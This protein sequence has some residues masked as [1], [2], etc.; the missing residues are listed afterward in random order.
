MAADARVASAPPWSRRAR[1]APSRALAAAL[2]V[3]G[4]YR[5]AR[6][7][8]PAEAPTALATELVGIPPLTF[9][10]GDINGEP[11]EYPERQITVKGFSLERTEV[12]NV[13]YRA[14]VAAKACDPTPYLDDGAL[15]A[16]DHPVVGVSW[17]DA[18]RYCAWVGRRLPTEAEWEAAARGVD[19]RR[20]PWGTGFD[21]KRANTAAAGGFHGKTAPVTG[22]PDGASPF[23]VLNL[24]GNAAEWVADYYDPTFHRR[25]DP[26]TTDPTGPATGRERVVRGGSYRDT[27]HLVRVSSRRGQLPT[28]T[29]STIGFRCAKS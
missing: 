28:E 11:D 27:M 10:M 25:P 5:H 8:A 4:C 14:C 7:D 13:A 1:G 21:A 2:L 26:V 18:T 6:R 3:G 12:T 9:T 29:D 17:L 22:Y 15:G 16:D 19:Q 24:A 20:Y 23:G